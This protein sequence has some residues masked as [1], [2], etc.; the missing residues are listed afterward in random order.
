MYRFRYTIRMADTDAA[1]VLF[2]AAQF[3]IAHEA[4]EAFLE[5]VG[6]SLRG[7]LAG[8]EYALP[9]VHAESD[10]QAPLRVGDVVTVELRADR[11][12]RT[13]F[14]LRYRFRKPRGLEV[15][16]SSTTHVAVSPAT[17]R[18]R[19]LPADL[20]DVLRTLRGTSERR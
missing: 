14:R 7:I 20:A 3:R 11:V 4:F 19:P 16:S 8:G 2:F 15:G 6:I 13:S 12:G 17:G 9:I 5:S 10:Y 18:P 1:G